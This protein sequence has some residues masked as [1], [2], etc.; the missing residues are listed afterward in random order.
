MFFVPAMC[1]RNRDHKVLEFFLD[2]VPAAP[3]NYSV[4]KQKSR[5]ER[6]SPDLTT[7]AS[8]GI[9][10]FFLFPLLLSLDPILAATYSIT[11]VDY[12]PKELLV[13]ISVVEHFQ[14]AFASMGR[15]GRTY[16]LSLTAVHSRAVEHFGP[17]RLIGKR[18]G[19]ELDGI[20]HFV[21]R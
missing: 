1:H 16:P 4:E 17:I 8:F 5:R 14:I 15:N 19:D 6:E 12:I 2:L 18:F 11:V 7:L 21:T 20:F 3:S 9:N 10:D 13:E